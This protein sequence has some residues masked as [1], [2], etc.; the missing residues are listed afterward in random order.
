MFWC[1]AIDIDECSQPNTCVQ[2]CQNTQGSFTCSC[3]AGYVKDGTRGCVANDNSAFLLFANRLDVRKYKLDNTDYTSL[4]PTLSNAI[5]VDFHYTRGIFFWTDVTLDVIMRANINGS[6]STV[7][8][9]QG[10]E[11]PGGL[12]VDW[13]HDKL[14]WTDSVSQRIEVS[15]L[16]GNKRKVVVL[17]HVDKP[18]AIV[19]DPCKG[20]MYWTDWGAN[21]RIERAFM[22]GRKHQVVVDTSIYWP[23]GL[24]IDYITDQLYWIDAKFHNLE[25]VST[26][27]HGRRT[28]IG[29]GLTHPFSVT[30]FEDRL[31]WTDWHTK[32]INSSDL[33]GQRLL[34]VKESLYF[35]MDI[36]VHH[37]LRQPTCKSVSR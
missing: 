20:W 7:V 9:S 32:S 17:E 19:V 14:Y 29:S 12:A 35:P 5:A 36:H 21:P 13:I 18:R 4:V 25:A 16:D 15:D 22:D 33:Q 31:Y 2:L 1:T 28:I 30:M 23:N 26:D 10:L 11:S 24:T 34:T 6:G 8:V 27:G 3:K 37:R